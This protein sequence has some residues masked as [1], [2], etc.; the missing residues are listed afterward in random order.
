ML[1]A[2]ASLFLYQEIKLLFSNCIKE[3]ENG[4]TW[5]GDS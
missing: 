5:E 1:E 4:I 2:F 3:A